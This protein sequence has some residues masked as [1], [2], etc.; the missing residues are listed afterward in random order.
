MGQ[1]QTSQIAVEEEEAA[2][3]SSSASPPATSS[4]SDDNDDDIESKLVQ[5]KTNIH[6][7]LNELP[8]MRA[9]LDACHV[10]EMID[11]A[12]QSADAALHL[13]RD[14]LQKKCEDDP[15]VHTGTY[16][17]QFHVKYIEQ[18]IDRLRDIRLEHLSSSQDQQS[19]DSTVAPRG[20]DKSISGSTIANERN[21]GPSGH[22]IRH[23]LIK[24]N[25]DD[26][27]D[28]ESSP[29]AAGSA[30]TAST[31]AADVPT[32]PDDSPAL[33]PCQPKDND[34]LFIRNIYCT[35]PGTMKYRN[36]VRER[37]MAY[38]KANKYLQKRGIAHSILNEIRSSDPPGRFLCCSNGS[39]S[40]NDQTWYTICDDQAVNKIQRSLYHIE[41][42][43]PEEVAGTVQAHVSPPMTDNALPDNSEPC[44]PTDND[45]LTTT[46]ICHHP[47]TIK[48]RDLIRAHAK[49]YK[50]AKNSLQKRGIIHTILNEIRS[51]D[52]PGRFLRHSK[53]SN[54][55]SGWHE[56]REAAAIQKV[57]AAYR[58]LDRGICN[59]KPTEKTKEGGGRY[60]KRKTEVAEQDERIPSKYVYKVSG[61]WKARIHFVGQTRH[62]GVFEERKDAALAYEV[63]RAK[64]KEAKSNS[65][66]RST[67]DDAFNEARRAA[68]DGVKNEK[69]PK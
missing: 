5:T 55:L 61:K 2:P 63:A 35:H 13:L 14:Q 29:P 28:T 44:Q 50:I 42:P 51:Q 52:P 22:Q 67:P 40:I 39:N 19:V 20:T 31:A 62:I 26:D 56:I 18:S 9:E 8:S 25:S 37:A 38:K 6:N 68:L 4:P 17:L 64:L 59:S 43:M 12:I 21:T 54:S 69:N 36:L 27:L 47:G 30:V 65:S 1:S 49:A 48:Y 34:V 7:F 23:I 60:R 57:Q 33:E 45:V 58:H 15:I 16:R 32:S 3:S 24:R 11:D 46:G 66:I 41:V 53:G 10:V